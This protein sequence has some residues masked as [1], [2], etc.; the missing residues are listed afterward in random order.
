MEADSTSPTI[1]ARAIR[2]QRKK[3]NLSAAPPKI[4]PRKKINLSAAPP[5]I[6]PRVTKKA[7]VWWYGVG[8]YAALVLCLSL[9]PTGYS[10]GSQHL[11]KVA[12]FCKY[13]VFAWFVVRAIQKTITLERLHLLWAWMFTASYGL[14][15]E[16]L[17]ALVPWRTGDVADAVANGIGAGLGV[18]LGMNFPARASRV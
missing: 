12:H 5:K 4:S 2:T 8:A 6:P 11:D 16:L 15:M 9:M 1:A 17:Q 13:L 7:K 18:W 10:W 3:I 14:L